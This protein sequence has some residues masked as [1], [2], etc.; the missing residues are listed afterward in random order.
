[1]NHAPAFLQVRPAEPREDSANEASRPR[2]RRPR[3]PVEGGQNSSIA[4][5]AE[6]S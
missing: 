5:E 3:N 2:R 6:E 1:V 4:E